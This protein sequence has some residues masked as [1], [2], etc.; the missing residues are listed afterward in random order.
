MEEKIKFKCQFC[1]SLLDSPKCV[2]GKNNTEYEFIMKSIDVDINDYYNNIKNKLLNKEKLTD[3]E[4]KILFLLLKNNV[5][6]DNEVLTNIIVDFLYGKKIVSYDVFEYILKI[7]CLQI[8]TYKKENLKVDFLINNLNADNE[9]GAINVINSNYMI[10]KLDENFIKRAYDNPADFFY[11]LETS[12]HELEHINQYYNFYHGKCDEKNMLFLKENLIVL[13]EKENYGSNN[14]YINNYDY[15]SFEKDAKIV[16]KVELL[17]FSKNNNIP[18]TQKIISIMKKEIE[19]ELELLKR[20][21]R[22]LNDEEKQDVYKIFDEVIKYNPKYL[23]TYSQLNY[24][25]IID[26]GIVR[27]RTIDE[28]QTV[29]KENQDNKEV[30]RYVSWLI[31]DIRKPNDFKKM[32]NNT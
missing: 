16:G 14:Y 5:L 13:N 31:N 1:G 11:F 29:L 25:Y 22:I 30:L 7:W 28:L 26:D 3:T 12:F 19:D 20:R 15:I 10:M 32:S 27:P 17:N 24:E 8:A 6:Y 18:L 4:Q 9:Y 23:T 2:C 21:I